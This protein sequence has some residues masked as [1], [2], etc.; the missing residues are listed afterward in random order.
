MRLSKVKA[1][2]HCNAKNCKGTIQLDKNMM[3]QLGNSN[4]YHGS[5]NCVQLHTCER[6]RNIVKA[7]IYTEWLREYIEKNKFKVD[8]L[9]TNIGFLYD[10]VTTINEFK[11]LVFDHECTFE[12]RA[13]KSVSPNKF[14]CKSCKVLVVKVQRDA[15]I[16][17]LVSP[18]GAKSKPL[19]TMSFEYVLDDEIPKL[20]TKCTNPFYI[21]RKGGGTNNIFSCGLTQ[22]MPE[23]TTF[24]QL[25]GWDAFFQENYTGLAGN[26][27]ESGDDDASIASDFTVN[28]SVDE[29]EI[30]DNVDED[31]DNAVAINR[32]LS[33]RQSIDR[34]E[35]IDAETSNTD[36]FWKKLIA[37]GEVEAI[38]EEEK[39]K[40][41][42]DG[43]FWTKLI[44]SNEA[45]EMNE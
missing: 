38:Y 27:D 34:D 31:L 8:C 39:E 25:F 37:S 9:K 17:K 28:M 30:L 14:I 18:D 43:T 42:K 24:I 22:I 32:Q 6:S 5:A 4:I 21:S 44:S 2:L 12:G 13:N 19:S 3:E 41:L 40:Q 33:I 36:T 15:H 45:E 20:K 1:L 26:D 10:Y 29:D 16:C 7:L 11:M 23:I 35:E